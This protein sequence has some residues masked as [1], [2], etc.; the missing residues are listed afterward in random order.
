MGRFKPELK[1]AATAIERGRADALLGARD[2]GEALLQQ[3]GLAALRDAIED[4]GATPT[5]GWHAFWLGYAAQFDDLAEARRHWLAAE[6]LFRRDGD[7][8]GMGLAACGLVQCV[9]IDQQSYEAFED[10]AERVA[11]FVDGADER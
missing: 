2:Q 1:L 5:S 7:A 9:L 4:S 10:W 8:P 3:R 6:Q 11:A